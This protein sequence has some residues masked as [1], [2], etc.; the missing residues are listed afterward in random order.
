MAKI[1]AIT[2]GPTEHGDLAQ[3]DRPTEVGMRG[4]LTGAE[5]LTR[6]TLTW[7]PHMGSPDRIINHAKPMADARTRDMTFND[8]YAH[9]AV[10]THKDS[11]VGTQF[12]LNSAPVIQV[13]K[14]F[15]PAFD[16]VWQE[17][18]SQAAEARF[19][20]TA[21]SDA[22]WLDASRSRSFTDDI[23]LA[24]A[25]FVNTGEILATAEWI[26]NDAQRPCKTA[27]QQVSPS[28]LSNPNLLADTAFMRRGIVKDARGRATGYYIRDSYPN[29]FYIGQPL[30]QW[31]LVPATKP[32]G[33][34]MVFHTFEALEVGQS[35]GVSDMVAALGDM[36]MAKKFREI[37]LQNAVIQASYAAAIESELPP[38]AVFQMM[39]GNSGAE[40][41]QGVM[42]IYMKLLESYFKGSKNTHIDGAQIPMLPPGTT[43]NTKTL[44]TPGGVG[45]DFETSL[46]RHVAAALGISTEE[47][48][49][50]FSGLSYSTVRASGEKMRRFMKARKK[51]GADRYANFIYQL[52]MEE[53]LNNGYLPLPRGVRRNDIF[54]QPLAKE[55]FCAANWIG[56]GTGQIDELKE[57][58]AAILRI[59]SGLSTWEKEIARLGDDWRAV[60]LQQ[61]RERA[62]MG[63][64]SLTFSLTTVR[65]GSNPDPVGAES[66]QTGQDQGAAA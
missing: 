63:Q 22:K 39:G 54:Y 60:F 38:E 52:W 15:N 61:Q 44:G 8:G 27:V 14:Q 18:F 20:L 46:H 57:T 30:F 33:R 3:I 45:D 4:G 47:Y 66:E 6:E 1:A 19:G 23:R 31:K 64:K 42:G 32:W 13:L 28:R 26:T 21:E 11:I 62:V 17:E 29:E 34:V 65:P 49:Q 50:D 56:S 59:A 16:E 7:Q 41:F 10:A 48:T 24:V 58:Q 53:E 37:T 35:R 43:L 5:S 25:Q 40:N 55:A 2:K 36:K 9:G 51:V 12:R